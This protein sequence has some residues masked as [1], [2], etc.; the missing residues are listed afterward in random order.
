MRD[1]WH[2]RGQVLAIAIV[3]ASGAA[4]LIM[5]RSTQEALEET[6]A[7]YYERYAFGDVFATLTRA[8]ASVGKRLSEVDGVRLV[9]TRISGFAMVELAHFD[10]PVVAQL[11]SLPDFGEPVLNRLALRGGRLPDSGADHEVVLNEPFAEA[12]DLR[13]GDTLTLIMNGRRKSFTVVGQVLSPEFAYSLG[14]GAVMPDN[15]RFGVMWINESA[16]A[17]TYD[18]RGGFNSV[19]LN[20]EPGADVPGV[21]KEVDALLQP[22]G[23]AGSLHRDDQLSN[24]FIRNEIKQL[25]IMASILP[26]IFLIVSAL[27]T[28]LVLARLIATERSQIGLLKAFGYSNFQVTMHYMKAVLVIVAIGVVA[29]SVLGGILGEMNTR[30]YAESFRFPLLVYSMDGKSLLVAT[31]ATLFA[32]VLGALGSVRRAS[33]LSPAQ[34]MVPPAPPAYRRSVLAASPLGRWLDRPTRMILR[35]AI[36]LPSRSAFTIFGL[37]SSVALLVVAFQWKDALLHLLHTV[38][39]EAQHQTMTVGL[40]ERHSRSVL[41]DFRHLPG[42]MAVEPASMVAADFNVGSITHRGAVTATCADVFL[43]PPYDTENMAAVAVPPEGLM[44]ATRL[45]RKLN[46]GVGD[47]VEVRFLEDRRPVVHVPVTGLFETFLGTPA[48]MHCD[49]VDRIFRRAPS[50]Q[51]VHLWVDRHREAEIYDVVRRVPAL[52]AV[53]LRTAAIESFQETIIAHLNVF[54]FIFAG[55]ACALCA[56][57]AYNA[58]RIALSERGRELATLRV[59]GFTRGEISYLLLGEVALLSIIGMPLGCL[60]GWML[61]GA[62][63]RAFDTELFRIPLVIEPSTYGYALLIALIATIIA[64]ALVNRRLR[65]LDLIEVLKTRE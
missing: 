14:P 28:H 54:I 46:V 1:L 41:G 3:I 10:E 29:G 47:L 35:N 48:Y 30:L 12:H 52:S 26:T 55:F 31:A 17:S 53:V 15:L 63:A 6:T 59:L 39:Y 7:A 62:M 24:W 38:Y 43:Q 8:P 58:N 13:P 32:S 64:G 5:F 4:T 42:V 60:L 9:Q 37:A 11:I 25:G 21:L 33:R 40:S 49:R 20:L 44:L 23:G 57:V 27:L 65:R 16:L 34:A 19:S 36:R 56:G 45:A 51:F 61:T 50:V 2:L 18:L 22:Y